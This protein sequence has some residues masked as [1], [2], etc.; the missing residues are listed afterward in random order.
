L[1]RKARRLLREDGA[2]ETPQALAPRRLPGPPAESEVP[3]AES[4]MYSGYGKITTI[5]TKTYKILSNKLLQ[6]G[7]PIPFLSQFFSF[8]RYIYLHFVKIFTK[9]LKT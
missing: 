7:K 9:Y 3:G 4:E 2:G 5:Y 1:E 8:Y 6:R